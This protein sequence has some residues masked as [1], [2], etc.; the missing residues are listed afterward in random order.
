MHCHRGASARPSGSRSPPR[1]VLEFL[2]GEAPQQVQPDEI[3]ALGEAGAEQGPGLGGPL[4][5][6]EAERIEILRPEMARLSLEDPIE[7]LVGL[8]EL[9]ATIQ[10]IGHQE[11]IDDVD[12]GALRAACSALAASAA[13]PSRLR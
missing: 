7:F 10:L 2:L 11:V 5:P 12:E 4:L 8:V 1:P 9:L 6:Q 3:G 13:S